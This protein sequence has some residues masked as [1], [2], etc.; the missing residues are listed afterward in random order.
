LATIR[1][2]S[3]WRHV[4]QWQVDVL[5][6]GIPACPIAR[7]EHLPAAAQ[8]QVLLRDAKAIVGFAQDL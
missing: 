7:P 6:S 2:A 8:A 4:H 3:S 1:R 5:R